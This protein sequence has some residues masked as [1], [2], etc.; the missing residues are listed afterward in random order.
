M[1]LRK[2]YA[3]LIKNFKLIHAIITVLS[4]YLLYRSI[5]I[6]DFLNNYISVL[7]ISNNSDVVSS[8]FKILMYIVPVLIIIIL[9]IIM[10]LMK[11]KEKPIL[12]YIF[13]IIVNIGLIVLYVYAKNI[14]FD[15]E[16]SIVDIRIVK[17]LRD[18]FLIAITIQFISLILSFIRATGF[19]IKKFDFVHDLQ[20]LDIKAE[21]S[22]EFE[23]NVTFNSNKFRRKINK[24]ARYLKYFYRENQFL[25]NASLGVIFSIVCGVIIYSNTVSNKTYNQGVAISNGNVNFKITDVYKTTKN[26]K[27]T[28][29]DNN[30]TY[31]IVGINL[32]T[33]YT[34][35]T[36]FKTGSIALVLGTH[37]Y[38]PVNSYNDIMS[39]FG[40][41]YTKQKLSNTF[42]PYVLIYQIPNSINNY[43]MHLE[44]TNTKKNKIKIKPINLDESRKPINYILGDTIDL[45]DSILKNGSLTIKSYDIKQK[46]ALNYNYC[47][48][49]NDC[50]NSI[51]YIVPSVSGNY[52]KAIL[53]LTGN[54]SYDD[55]S[56]ISSKNLYKFI[57][58][59]GNITYKLGDQLKNNK[60][61]LNNIVPSDVKINNDYYIE[62]DK[63]ILD[64]NEIYLNLNI[65]N[66]KYVYK[67]K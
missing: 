60:V 44:Y 56:H 4:G 66:M 64:A 43:K 50:I 14:I 17:I 30:N 36:Y 54:I 26:Y 61:I 9:F 32:Q 24:Y 2:P 59:Y 67:I 38:Y 22:E 28:V 58:L 33:P 55:N 8:L 3:F 20:E 65:R 45:K 5:L 10:L 51:E 46:Y 12:F 37:Y 15:M 7:Q 39:D 19:D 49:D 11:F 62:V 48:T 57:N 13:N 41:P 16:I 18:I 29:I 47:I 21:D 52:D 27:N 23:L 40:V 1:I 34:S 63:E 53:K 42:T 31:V 35:E 6:I 25:V